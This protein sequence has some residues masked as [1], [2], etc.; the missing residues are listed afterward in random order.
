M[1]IHCKNEDNH[2]SPQRL[3]TMSHNGISWKSSCD[4]LIEGGKN[5]RSWNICMWRCVQNAYRVKVKTGN[6]ENGTNN[7]GDNFGYKKN[8]QENGDAV[9]AVV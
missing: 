9:I 3:K 6:G 1:P 5:V 7:E 4:I 8:E 2:L